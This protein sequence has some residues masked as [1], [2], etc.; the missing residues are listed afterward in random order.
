MQAAR[1]SVK[2]D[3]QAE[4][5]TARAPSRQCLQP[6]NKNKFL[7]ST[8]ARTASVAT[9]CGATECARRQK[10]P[11]VLTHA[12]ARARARTRARAHRSVGKSSRLFHCMLWRT[13][14]AQPN[15]RTHAGKIHSPYRAHTRT[16]KRASTRAPVTRQQEQPLLSLHLV[17]PLPAS[18]APLRLTL[19]ED[20]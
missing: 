7:N 14:C 17:V 3:V 15:A 2:C 13:A 12:R 20:T 16:P 10:A 8:H 9:E 4:D 18:V 1:F 11:A 5:Q 19:I 6:K